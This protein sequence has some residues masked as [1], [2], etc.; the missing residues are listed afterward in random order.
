[1]FKPGWT[2]PHKFDAYYEQEQKHASH[3]PYMASDDNIVMNQRDVI[4]HSFKLTM[5]QGLPPTL[6]KAIGNHDCIWWSDEEANNKPA[7]R[8]PILYPGMLK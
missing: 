2:A 5:D 1:M 8:K 7:K 6:I 3:L 4:L